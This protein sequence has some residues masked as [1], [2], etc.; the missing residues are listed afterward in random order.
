MKN[1]TK[2]PDI[3]TGYRCSICFAAA[4]VFNAGETMCVEHAKMWGTNDT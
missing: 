1:T 3:D 2:L 4:Q